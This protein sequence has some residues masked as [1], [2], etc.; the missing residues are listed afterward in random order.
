[1]KI[2]L[3]TGYRTGSNSF[4]EWASIELNLPY[5]HE[6]FNKNITIP[7]II[8][9]KISSNKN[10]SIEEVGDC[11]M[12]ISPFDGFD[13]ENLKKLFDKRIVLYRENTKEQAES[14]LWANKKK[15][16]H[17]TYLNDK[18]IS[19][20]YTI[21]MEWLNK[22]EVEIKTITDSLTK[23]NELLKSLTDC[24]QITYE[25]LYYSE[26]GIK[27]IENYL[28]FKSKSMFNKIHKLRNGFIKK[29]LT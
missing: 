9:N 13:Y 19:A 11:I 16:W 8:A 15:L 6:P 26:E 17:H 3:Y 18:F 1:M 4:G 5:Y 27:K 28:G 2:L 21:P 22:N 29:S 24:L 23:V 25:E 12:K 7:S 14:I 20:H 10:I